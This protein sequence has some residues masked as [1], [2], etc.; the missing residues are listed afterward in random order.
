MWL[1]IESDWW[2]HIGLCVVFA[3][4]PGDPFRDSLGREGLALGVI[5]SSQKQFQQCAEGVSPA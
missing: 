5:S 1:L 4:A 2:L 3:D